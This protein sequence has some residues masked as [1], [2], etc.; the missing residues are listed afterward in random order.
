M[1]SKNDMTFWFGLVNFNIGAGQHDAI[2]LL[3]GFAL[4]VCAFFKGR[5]A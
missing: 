1:V 4:M 2:L 3:L 5:D